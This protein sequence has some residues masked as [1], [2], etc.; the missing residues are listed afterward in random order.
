M[1]VAENRRLIGQL[2]E[3]LGWLEDHSR[4]QPDL[5]QQTAQLRFATAMVRNVLGPFMDGQS[6]S[7][8]HIAVVGGAGTG[9]ST[10][11][12]FLVGSPAAESNP[13]AGYTRHP[14]AYIPSSSQTT[15]T[16]H[17]G[18]LG[19]LQRLSQPAPSNLDQ[20]VYQI[21]R[22]PTEGEGFGPIGD[23]VIWDCPDMT[24]WA[25]TGYVPRLLEVA[26]LADVIVY[27]ASDERYNDEVPT[28]FLAK[29]VNA[30]KPVVVCL[31]KMREQEAQPLVSHFQSEVLGQFP[32][33]SFRTPVP[34]LAI[35]FLTNEQLTDPA[36]NAGKY[37][38]PL[39]NQIAVLTDPPYEA[40]QR[41]LNQALRFLTSSTESLLEVARQDLAALDSWR[42]S[43]QTG[44]VEFD[45]RYRRE[46]LN[47]EK[48]RRFDDAQEKL[49][50]LLELPGAG[51]V[52]S[53][54][55]WFLRLPYRLLRN[56]MGRAFLRPEA[57]NLPEH[58]VLE[59]ALRAW[60]DG[61][62]AEAIRK[63]D[64]HPLWKYLNSGFASGLAETMTDR[65]EDNFR[66]FQ[67]G[68][69]D[70]IEAN[71]QGITLNL[72]KNHPKLA[73]FRVF[74]LLLDC[75]AI[76]VGFWIVGFD[77]LRFSWLIWVPI[78]V[79]LEHQI[80][81]LLVR[82]YV[83]TKRE[84]TRSRKQLMVSQYLSQPLADWLSQWPASGGSQYEKLQLALKRIPTTIRQIAEAI[85]EKQGATKST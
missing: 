64:T 67:L 5:A 85:V 73:S 81:E 13:Q 71:S 38:I 11:V 45:N 80:V 66:R 56:A 62:R 46:Y 77:F 37:R 82:G 27:V 78:L 69:A 16:S 2:S 63:A 21:K 9:K 51:K 36:K 41:T 33:S 3:D 70:E 52:V 58:D 40:R 49:L 44:Q 34:V 12:N 22:V 8:I 14:T 83:E 42:T 76:L 31:T 32:K 75:T 39:L 10:I 28:Q 24:T 65:F 43:V 4:R 72:I 26:G 20:D 17:L 60:I 57:V 48:F 47:S 7:P 35:P 23:C 61:L 84:Q 50:D 59:G 53:A 68:S 1:D 54:I 6:P 15:W 19:P 30:G 25:A 74:K 79:S 18:F 55:F 29:L